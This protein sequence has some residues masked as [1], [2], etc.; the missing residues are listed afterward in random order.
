MRQCE[1]WT[2]IVNIARGGSGLFSK[3]IA[4][5]E[6]KNDRRTW[7]K[8]QNQS[9]RGRRWDWSCDIEI[10]EHLVPSFVAYL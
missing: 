9:Q 7:V 8:E 4:V 6:L 2:S 5:G 1:L 3:V 10:Q